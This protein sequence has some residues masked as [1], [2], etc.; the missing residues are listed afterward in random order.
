M[1]LDEVINQKLKN[2]GNKLG[3]GTGPIFEAIFMMDVA[4][5]MKDGWVAAW[6]DLLESDANLQEKGQARG[7]HAQK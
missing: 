6:L 3:T 5:C 4:V 2:P 7:I 1:D